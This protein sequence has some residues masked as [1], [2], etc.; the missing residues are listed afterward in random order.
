MCSANTNKSANRPQAGWRGFWADE[1][2]VTAIEYG[3]L[4]SLI[5]IV[6]VG[7]FTAY[8]DALAAIFKEWSDAVLAAL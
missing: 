1:H 6:A 2:G 5:T 7:S 8:A 4:A 3:L